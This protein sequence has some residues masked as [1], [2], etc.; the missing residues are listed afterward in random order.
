MQ[1]Q[2]SKQ[3]LMLKTHNDLK[4]LN[5]PKVDIGVINCSITN[6]LKFVGIK[7]QY[8]LLLFFS[9]GCEG[10]LCSAGQRRLVGLSCGCSQTIAGA[11]VILKPP[12]LNLFGAWTGKTLIVGPALLGLLKH[13]LLSCSCSLVSPH[14]PSSITTAG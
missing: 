9:H 5:Q 8:H 4:V 2:H 1:L 10:C 11:R 14:G 3:R 13:L 6:H 12:S 7:E